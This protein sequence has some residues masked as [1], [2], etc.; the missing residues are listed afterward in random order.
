MT[1]PGTTSGHSATDTTPETFFCFLSWYRC[2]QFL[3]CP[4][5]TAATPFSCLPRCLS[6]LPFLPQVFYQQTLV[7]APHLCSLPKDFSSCF[8]LGSCGSQRTIPSDL[9]SDFQ[10]ADLSLYC[11]HPQLGQY[12][13]V[14]SLSS[15]R[16]TASR[17]LVYPCLVWISDQKSTC[18]CFSLGYC[19]AQR[20]PPCA[21]AGEL[22]GSSRAGVSEAWDP[23]HEYLVSQFS[24]ARFCL[25]PQLT[26]GS[27]SPAP[28]R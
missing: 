12:H 1:C 16:F 18:R 10:T 4:R 28:R 3:F 14:T 26:N 20:G 25:C 27:A 17:T 21:S 24:P 11:R 19:G 7:G 22:T 23:M 9:I 2:H 8:Q 5:L 6:N 15:L 13:C